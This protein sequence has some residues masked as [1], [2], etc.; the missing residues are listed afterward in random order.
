MDITKD[1]IKRAILKA[2]GNPEVGIIADLADEMAQEVSALIMPP[3]RSADRE[4]RISKP[5]ELR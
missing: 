5:S 3:T 4:T 2:A 1:Q